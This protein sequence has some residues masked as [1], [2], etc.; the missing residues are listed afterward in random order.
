[1]NHFTLDGS[2]SL[3]DRLQRLCGDVLE[4][5]QALLPA[6]ALEALVLGGGYGRGEGGVRRTPDGEEPYNDLE[7]YVF[8]IGNRLLAERKYRRALQEL[9]ERLSP[10]AGLHVEFKIESLPE[11]RRRPIS[12]FSYD[13]V[14]SHR[15][16][17]G[18]KDFF[19][20]CARHLEAAKIPLSEATRL[21]FNRCTGLL[22]AKELLAPA[23]NTETHQAATPSLR[24]E[25]ADFIS[26]NVAKAQL[27][28]GDA[29]LTAFHSYHWS[30]RERHQRLVH[31]ATRAPSAD[32]PRGTM[33]PQ[34]SRVVEFHA[35]GV[36]FKLHP[37]R[38]QCSTR[39]L[40]REHHA[41]SLAAQELW[42]WLESI[43]LGRRFASAQEYALNLATKLPHTSLLRNCL[44][45]LRAFGFRAAGSIMT[46]RYPR[47]R[48]LNCLPLLLWN[49]EL[50]NEPRL[51]RHVQRQLH[52]GARDWSGL[53][54]AYKQVWPAYG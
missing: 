8:V 29:V 4:G 35:R 6:R 44:L 34:L 27:A 32:L 37:Q 36:E 51:R 1:M 24:E 33:P 54:A 19:H 18:P 48:L 53:V 40:A 46:C 22:L 42:L 39:Q 41:T 26:R 30:C 50:A 11:F 7:F 20:G 2:K 15:T 9:G 28:L 38:P 47:E 5:V 45:N 10:R 52:T 49:G 31:F 25:D 17:Y 13:L 14:A 21:L 43:R 16:I 3:E 12:M 23:E